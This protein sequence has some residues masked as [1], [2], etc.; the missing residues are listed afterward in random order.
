MISSSFWVSFWNVPK[1]GIRWTFHAIWNCD[2]SSENRKNGIGS[3]L[4]WRSLMLYHLL[5]MIV[6]LIFGIRMHL[7]CYVN[8]RRDHAAS[9]QSIDLLFNLLSMYRDNW[10]FIQRQLLPC[11]VSEL[12][13]LYFISRKWWR[14]RYLLWFHH[15]Y[16]D[17]SACDVVLVAVTSYYV[18]SS[19]SHSSFFSILSPTNYIISCL[20]SSL[21]KWLTI[22]RL[23]GISPSN[24]NM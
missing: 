7:S 20:T 11:V 6:V 1:R 14:I 24:N 3:T 2:E 17:E 10:N 12:R 23:V 5:H 19:F 18:L 22:R 16:D 9:W 15:T 21:L 13:F 8:T 4:K